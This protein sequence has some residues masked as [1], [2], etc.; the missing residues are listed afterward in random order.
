MNADRS[1]AVA[2]IR[3]RSM[4]IGEPARL[5]CAYGVIGRALDREFKVTRLDVRLLALSGRFHRSG[6]TAGFDP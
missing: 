6:R 3:R 1:L 5:Q 4:A 2:S